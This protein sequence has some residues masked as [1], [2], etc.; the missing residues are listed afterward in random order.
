MEQ[1]NINDIRREFRNITFSKFQKSKAKQELLLSMYYTKIEN[2]CYWCAEFICAGHFLDLWD[3]IILYYCKYIY[4]GNPKLPIYLSMRFNNFYDILTNGYSSNILVLRNNSKIRKIFSEIICILCYSTKKHIYQDIKLKKNEEFDLINISN[5]F[6]APNVRYIDNIMKDDDPKELLIPLNELIYNL[7]SKNIIDTCYWFEWIMEYE[8]ICKKKK[9][10]CIT[11]A[12]SYAPKGEHNDIIWII[13]DV[14]FFYSQEENLQLNISEGNKKILNKII[15]SL[16][17]L[18]IIKYSCSVKKKRKYIIYYCFNLLI[19]NINLNIPFTEK[20]NEIQAIIS[21]IDSIYKEIKKNEIS[22]GTD[23]LF[24]NL[25]KSN[26]E[27][28]I[29]KIEIIN[30][31]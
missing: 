17:E 12:R 21:K 30:N 11:Q 13:W 26:I 10:K 31:I 19:E 3:I 18:F 23:Y 5:R 16:Y 1:D 20:S 7:V 8:I 24:T 29:E 4:S 25:K 15:K 28:T 22:P 14:I 27:K 9:K 2:A 6:K